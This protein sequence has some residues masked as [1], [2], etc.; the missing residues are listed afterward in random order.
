MILAILIGAFSLGSA[1]PSL[2]KVA[3]SG[4]SAKT[5]FE[6]MERKSNIDPLSDHGFKPPGFTDAIE[7]NNIFFKY[8]T[9]PDVNV[10][11]NFSL[12]IEK[13]KTVALVGASGSGKS[14]AIKLLERFYDPTSGSV[15][16]DSKDIKDI[17]VS[18]LR[19]IMGL[20]SQEPALFDNTIRENIR[21][22]IPN[23]ETL[24]EDV[25]DK[26]IEDACRKSNC[27]DFIQ[28]F[29][30][31]L[32]TNVGES[33][34]ILSGGQKQRI[35][36]ARTIIKNPPILLLDEVMTKLTRQPQHWTL[37]RNELCKKRLTL[38]LM[39]EPPL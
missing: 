14:T 17:N 6:T 10:M 9:R 28:E 20:V 30:E 27:W 32:N 33:G 18:W 2:K 8:E 31:K 22:G 1:T 36:I 23:V 12:K 35:A 39:T 26:L 34:S 4:A 5:I 24:S 3:D 37:N 16:L 13:G 21:I 19:G 29:P 38:Y 7:F 15:Q 11:K 25:I